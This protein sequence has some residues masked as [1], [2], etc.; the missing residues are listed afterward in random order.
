MKHSDRQPDVLG[1]IR[2]LVVLIHVYYH[3]KWYSMV[4][5]GVLGQVFRARVWKGAPVLG[6]CVSQTRAGKC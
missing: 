1:I 5:S 6:G 3:S 2:S 4:H